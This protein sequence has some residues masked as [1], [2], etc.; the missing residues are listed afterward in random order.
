MVRLLNM[1]NAFHVGCKGMI[2]VLNSDL[3]MW[4]ASLHSAPFL[5]QGQ[6]DPEQGLAS[7]LV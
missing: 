1:K 4:Q 7:H 3:P 5:E 6:L 2:K